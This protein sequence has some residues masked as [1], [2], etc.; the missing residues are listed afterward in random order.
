MKENCIQEDEIDLKEIC[1]TLWVKKVFIVVF[2]LFVTIVAVGYV[3]LKNPKPVYEGKVLIEIGEIQSQTFG[4]SSFD[5]P[6]N[7]AEIL[8]AKFFVTTLSPRGTNKIIEIQTAQEDKK[9][10]IKKLEK[11]VEYILQ[12]H[13]EKAEFYKQHIMTQQI[14]D[15]Q[16]NPLPVNEINKKK[17]IGVAFVSGLIL[18]VFLVFFMEFIK[19][20]KEE[21]ND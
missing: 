20:F 10:I 2:T 7:L 14:G 1:K 21:K 17:I 15:I 11:T 4:S 13:Q 12:R 18:S 9:K 5:T 6:N 8:K 16:I 19:G 3:I